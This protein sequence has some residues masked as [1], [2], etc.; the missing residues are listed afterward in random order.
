MLQLRNRNNFNNRSGACA[1]EIMHVYSF[2]FL[3]QNIEVDSSATYTV[4]IRT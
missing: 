3:F 2:T 4:N 1:I